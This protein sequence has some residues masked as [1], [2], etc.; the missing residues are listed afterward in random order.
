MKDMTNR[1]QMWLHPRTLGVALGAM[2]LVPIVANAQ[3]NVGGGQGQNPPNQ[4]PGGGGNRPDFRN[5][6]PEQQQQYINQRRAEMQDR[7][8][9]GAMTRGGFNNTAQQDAVVAYAKQQDAS[10]Q[11]LQD[12][13]K[14]LVVA[15]STPNVGDDEVARQLKEFQAA[16]AKEKERR[17]AARADLDKQVNY[18][19][20]PRLEMLLTMFGLVG[21]DSLSLGN[22]GGR[23]LGGFGGRGGN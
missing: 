18:T 4:N 9:R 1:S 14:K 2:L 15:V 13:G 3:P 19:K 8:L 17:A 21:D 10:T 5:M 23:F 7:M 6:T 12:M 16:V 22:M 20:Q 11:S